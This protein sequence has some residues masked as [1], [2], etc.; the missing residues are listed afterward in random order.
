MSVFNIDI[1]NTVWK[2]LL[3]PDKR[4]PKWRA[5]GSSILAGS[6]WKQNAFFTGYMA[7]SENLVVPTLECPPNI[8]PEP[9]V[10]IP[11][12]SV[13]NTTTTYSPGQTVIYAVQG[14]T[15]YYGDNAVYQCLNTCEGAMYAPY[16]ANVAPDVA[17]AW[18]NSNLTEAYNYTNAATPPFYWVKVQDNFIGAN[19]RVMYNASRL[20]FE[21]ALNKWFYNSDTHFQQPVAGNSSIYIHPNIIDQD[22]LYMGPAGNGYNYIPAGYDEAMPYLNLSSTPPSLFDFSIYFPVAIYNDLVS[23][24]IEIAVG[25]GPVTMTTLR[26][27]IVQA[28]ANKYNAAGM[29]YNIITY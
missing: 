10:Y 8:T 21:W 27:S 20:V 28:F 3:P 18:A 17:P 12:P 7:G 26:A 5:W 25:T 9:L 6:Q 19:E 11:A 15:S 16:G 22:M 14:G 23:T 4:L 2:L 29:T 24:S 1:I 13:Y